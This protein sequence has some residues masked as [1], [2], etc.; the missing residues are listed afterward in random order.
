MP[1]IAPDSAGTKCLFFDLEMSEVK[2]NFPRFLFFLW[3]HL[4]WIYEREIWR[5]VKMSECPSPLSG[6]LWILILGRGSRTSKAAYCPQKCANMSRIYT[7]RTSCPRAG[8]CDPR[9]YVLGS[10]GLNWWHPFVG[11]D[12]NQHDVSICIMGKAFMRRGCC[13]VPSKRSN[14]KL[15]AHWLG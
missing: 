13:G 6:H 4:G 3:W 9:C 11:W 12:W 14:A 5:G 8:L 7:G 10:I 1:Y 2:R 15:R